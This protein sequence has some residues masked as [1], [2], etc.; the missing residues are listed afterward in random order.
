MLIDSHCHLDFED[1]EKEGVDKIVETANSNGV[2]HMVTINIQI[3]KF[4]NVINIANKFDTVECTVGT[5]PCHADEELEKKVTLDEL[6]E[7]ASKDKVIGI[8]ETGLDYFHE[9]D[10]KDSQIKSFQ[11]HIDACLN[12]DLPIIIHSRNADEDMI[13]ILKENKGLRGVLHC[14]SS[15]RELAEE[16]LKLG[17]Y[18][19]ASG[20]ITFKNAVELQ[21]IM[22]D[23]PLDRLLVETDSPYLAPVPNRGS[24]NEPAFVKHTALALAKLKNVTEEEIAEITTNNFYNLF[25]KSK[26]KRA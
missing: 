1:F 26:G 4:D 7:L 10:T 2:G 18:I 9:T 17:F 15:S 6:I 21:S 25:T 3:A 19:S 13:R 23:V 5:H 12:L 20:I 8:G 24:R 11:K 16:A 22:A 14:F